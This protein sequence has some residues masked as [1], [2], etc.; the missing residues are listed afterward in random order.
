[1]QLVNF[2]Y[3]SFPF[4]DVGPAFQTK[5]PEKFL[6]FLNDITVHG[7][8]DCPEMS[9]TAIKKALELSLPGSVIYVF[10][11]A[12][13]KDHQMLGEV[14][15]LIT[16]KKIRVNFILTGNCGLEKNFKRRNTYERIAILSSGQIVNINK[17]DIAK[18]WDYVKL[19]INP[20]RKNIF[21][22]D[23]LSSGERTY[24]IQI[25][26]YIDVV[27]I[28]VSGENIEV[29]IKDNAG[30]MVHLTDTNVDVLLNLPSV[31]SV[32]M[33]NPKEGNWSVKVRSVEGQTLRVEAISDYWDE[34]NQ[35]HE[36]NVIPS[37]SIKQRII[38]LVFF[39]NPLYTHSSF[40]SFPSL[41]NFFIPFQS[42]TVFVYPLSIIDHSLLSLSIID[43]LFSFH[44]TRSER[45]LTK[46]S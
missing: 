22:V 32:L 8:H 26:Q 12:E 9:V 13:A 27:V 36:V 11:D 1:M 20:N 38:S 21:S 3:L 15:Q 39:I 33:R 35:Q 23:K 41:A 16:R 14:V 18:I 43:C 42:T 29:E 28:T 30:E 4:T 2:V 19:S 25:D 46:N 24:F 6:K 7:G 34:I 10:T 5:D 45:V 31:L 17:S 40:A 37:M 44:K